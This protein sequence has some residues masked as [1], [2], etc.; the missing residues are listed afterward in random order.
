MEITLDQLKKIAKHQKESVLSSFVDPLNKLFVQFEINTNLKVCFYLAN[1][2]HE[3]TECQQPA[4]EISPLDASTG[5][6]WNC[7]TLQIITKPEAAN[8]N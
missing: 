6:C 1:I 2:L 7:H 3:C 4:F 8:E 5:F